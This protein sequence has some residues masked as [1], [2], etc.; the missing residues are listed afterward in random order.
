MIRL[1]IFLELSIFLSS[2]SNLNSQ[3]SNNE[4]AISKD[5]SI[6]PLGKRINTRFNV[7]KGF[8]RDINDS[9]SFASYLQNLPL[10][11]DGS[12]VHLFDGRIK[13]N[14]GIYLGV[15]DLSI[16][17]KDLHQCADAVMR[18]R[19]E[20]LFSQKKY[21][22]I[23]F[24]TASGKQFGYMIWLN[25]REPNKTNFWNYL[26]ALFNVANTTS[27]NKQL[28]YKPIQKLEIGDVFI[29]PWNGNIPGHA[30]IVVDKCLNPEG[31][32]KFMLAQSFMPA[33][34]LQILNNPNDDGSPWYS[35]EFGK[36]LFTS[37]I[38][39]TKNQLK[40]FE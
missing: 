7:P 10:K 1:L 25:G 32:V 9:N 2:C 13:Q 38:D 22:E 5:A 19:A 18:L 4:I 27:L 21:N 39:F 24:L 37:E 40:S 12:L 8:E 28:K 34:E 14:N 15:I 23:S 31:K 36:T 35:L 26:E 3:E 6:I 16:G 11:K 17:K 33:Q 29:Y 30:I 20:Y